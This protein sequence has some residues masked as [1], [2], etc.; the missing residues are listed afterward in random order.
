MTAPY[1]TIHS[2]ASESSGGASCR[3]CGIVNPASR[4]ASRS[5]GFSETG[6][7]GSRNVQSPT[8]GGRHT[9]APAWRRQWALQIAQRRTK[10]EEIRLADRR[11]FAPGSET[12]E[13]MNGFFA[14][15][16]YLA[17]IVL[18]PLSPIRMNWVLAV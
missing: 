17:H 12:L 10:G 11:S 13:F 9:E 14:D 7:C 4:P 5:S 6:I 18:R 8:K 3:P 16:D 1:V 15:S 2:Q